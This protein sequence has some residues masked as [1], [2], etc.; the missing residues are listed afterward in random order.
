MAKRRTFKPEFK[1]RVVL[2]GLTGVKS[3]AEICRKHQAKPPTH[4]RAFG[5]RTF[6]KFSPAGKQSTW[7]AYP[8][9]LPPSRAAATSRIGSSSWNGWLGV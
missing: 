6:G 4:G 8:R 5:G 3:T 1:A 7:D 9:S 2:E